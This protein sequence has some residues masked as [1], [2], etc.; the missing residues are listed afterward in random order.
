[1]KLYL[2]LSKS[3]T[4]WFGY[5]LATQWHHYPFQILLRDAKYCQ[6]Y[7]HYLHRWLVKEQ[8]TDLHEGESDR[9]LF[10][11]EIG[12]LCC[13][14]EHVQQDT[15]VMESDFSLWLSDLVG[16]NLSPRK[17][18]SGFT[19]F[20]VLV[21]LILKSFWHR[22]TFQETV[23]LPSHWENLA[24]SCSLTLYTQRGNQFLWVLTAR[25]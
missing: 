5:F 14:N 19:V 25:Y 16:I 17:H 21:F 7:N 10:S 23:R 22:F 8:W 13:L 9:N 2:S 4:S 3:P 18:M 6:R 15:N 12:C 20:N 24:H 1:M 11:L